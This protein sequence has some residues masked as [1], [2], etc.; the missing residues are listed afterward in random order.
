[1]RLKKRTRAPAGRYRSIGAPTMKPRT[2]YNAWM[3]LIVVIS[4]GVGGL[5]AV[6]PYWRPTEDKE[7]V[8]G[9]RPRLAGQGM[10]ELQGPTRALFHAGAP[11]T[12]FTA[13]VD[14]EMPRVPD[15]PAG[16]FSTHCY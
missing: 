3:P 9:T 15:D 2:L 16:V 11:F 14:L 8:F 6:W 4:V 13:T 7:L 10:T 1:M 5:A 12:A